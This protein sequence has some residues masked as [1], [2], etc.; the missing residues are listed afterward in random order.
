MNSHLWTV[1]LPSY[2]SRNVTQFLS[3]WSFGFLA[4]YSNKAANQQFLGPV[5][6]PYFSWAEPNKLSPLDSC[7]TELLNSKRDTLSPVLSFGLLAW[8]SN[9]AAYQ[10]FLKHIYWNFIESGISEIRK[11]LNLW[12][13]A[14]DELG[15]PYLWQ[16]L[17][18]I[19]PLR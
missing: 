15:K 9:M 11:W 10:Q 19:D 12:V 5:H 7:F 16:N 6:T 4:W 8:H 13:I 17:L 3:P 2:L 1:V 18:E 14:S